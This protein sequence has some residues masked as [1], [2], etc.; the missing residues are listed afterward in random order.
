MYNSQPV[1]NCNGI[2]NRVKL[3]VV[4]PGAIESSGNYLYTVF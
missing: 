3:R 4:P 1:P 2:N